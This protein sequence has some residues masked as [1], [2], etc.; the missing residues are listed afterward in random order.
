MSFYALKVH[1]LKYIIYIYIWFIIFSNK[2]PIANKQ[3]N[4][5][6]KW[7]KYSIYQFGSILTILLIIPRGLTLIRFFNSEPFYAPSFCSNWPLAQ[8]SDAPMDVIIIWIKSFKLFSEKIVSLVD[9]KH[10]VIK[11][12]L[13][14][15]YKSL[16][17]IM[18]HKAKRNLI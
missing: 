13:D 4:K 10:V 11:L 1:I 7:N 16:I 2:R 17:K 18:I 5:T 15:F 8:L 9:F 14:L 6:F 3:T 12:L